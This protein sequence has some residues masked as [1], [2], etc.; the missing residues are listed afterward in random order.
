VLR[1]EKAADG[2]KFVWVITVFHFLRAVRKW[3]LEANE[4]FT[5]AT[6]R[7]YSFKIITHTCGRSP[8]A[9]STYIHLM[10][11]WFGHSVTLDG[12]ERR[13]LHFLFVLEWADDIFA[14]IRRQPNWPTSKLNTFYRDWTSHLLYS[15]DKKKQSRTFGFSP[16]GWVTAG[17]LCFRNHLK[18]RLEA[19]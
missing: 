10:R 15:L 2:P 9:K 19:I 1:L 4:L 18:R 8:K 12:K 11:S 6:A 7:F 14:H 3:F 16:N 17:F 5:I 13:L